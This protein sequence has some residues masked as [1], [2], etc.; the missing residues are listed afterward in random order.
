VPP[1]APIID[2]RC[3][4]KLAVLASS[5]ADINVYAAAYAGDGNWQV[6]K[7]QG[8]ALRGM[9][10]G[11]L[12]D[13]TLVAAW[14]SRYDLIAWTKFQFGQTALT[15]PVSLGNAVTGADPS[16]AAI[17]TPSSAKVFYLGAN[18]THFEGSYTSATGWNAATTAIPSP[19]NVDGGV[20]VP[21]KSAPAAAAVGT[22]AVI[23]YTGT[24]TKLARQTY[25]GGSWG[26]PITIP[27]ADAFAQPPAMVP[28]DGGTK[29]LLLVYV[30][31]D[32]LL[33]STTREQSNKAWNTAILV[34]SA[35]SPNEP[36]ELAPMPNGRAMLVF[37]ASNNQAYFSVYDPTKTKPWSV[38]AE[39]VAGK[40][41]V[42]V[43]TPSVVE[44]HCG[45][46]A[47]VAYSEVGAGVSLMRYDAAGAWTGP[48]AVP[49]LTGMTFVGA[50]ELP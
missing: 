49:G 21:G 46:D 26:G 7:S 11:V 24:D 20:V 44:G 17:A 1:G 16:L 33:H 32:L 45:S 40:N 30:G 19:T 2:A 27:S 28:M 39:L 34:D 38:P 12:V 31:A 42:V 14:R 4:G 50:G 22:S 37:K 47:T 10:R 43:N 9:P 48:F 15:P 13:G 23:G 18:N 29:D 41:P 3:I 35:A 8:P 25:S 6:G 5:D 36:P